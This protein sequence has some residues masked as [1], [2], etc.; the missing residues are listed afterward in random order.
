MR[1]SVVCCFAI[2]CLFSFLTVSFGFAGDKKPLLPEDLYQI[3]E[4]TDL[5]VS[6]DGQWIA[7]VMSVPNLAENDAERAIWLMPITG[8]TSRRLTGTGSNSDSPRWS[9]NGKQLAFIS[10]RE[11][12]RNLYLIDVSGGE[13]RKLTN[14]KTDLNSPIWSGKG[15]TIL[16]ASRVLP[17]G[18]TNIENWTKKELPKC[19]ARAIDRL[20]FRQWD[21]WLGDERNH[22]FLVRVADG[23][24]QDITPADADVPPVSLTTNHD[25]DMAPDGKE[26]CY[27]RND[28]PVLAISTNQDIFL[29]DTV[30]LKEKKLTENTALDHQPHYSPDGRYIAYTAMAKPGYESDTERLMLY[31]RKTGTHTV[32][33]EKLDRTVGQILWAPNNKALYFTCNDQ[34]HNSIYKV[35][36][37]GNLQL[38]SADGFNS[39]IVLTPQEERLIF[40]RGYN[41]MPY[42]IFSLGLVGKEKNKVVQLT[43]QNSEFLAQHELPKLEDFHFKGADDTLVHGYILRPP[44]FDPAK[45]YPVVLVIHGGPQG[46]FGD[47]LLT[48]WWTYQLISAPGYVGVFINPRGSSGYGAL[49]REQVSKDYGG[50]CF[51]DLMKGL[52]HVLAHYDFVDKEKCAA[53][54]GS[55]GGYSVN[56]IMGHSD[57]FKCIVSHA[58][59]YNLASF[60]GATEELWYAAWD[61]GETPWD[62]PKL[63][64]QW[65]PHMYAKNFKTPT[66]I[67]H[68]EMDF[69]VPFGESLQLFTTLQRRGIPSR[70]VVFP[71][72]GHI[73]TIPQNNVRWWKEIQRWLALYLK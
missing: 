28:A 32:L 2:V 67:T 61:L 72:E 50:R 58:G 42:E 19:E 49:F 10:N 69:R 54:G 4:L 71:D 53:V 21:R 44:G 35:D 1:K 23:S 64:V 34:G 62:E 47:E 8:G 52:D 24:S 14:S 48:T 70:L 15:E 60:Y 31:E 13:A 17:E 9:P 38:V 43:R 7:Y 51:E 65:S 36:L 20:L 12:T 27:T 25:F 22:L 16:C 29:L 55:F 6:P 57:R 30:T 56:W 18:K 11:K 68:G 37:K 26:V 40:L 39:S 3:K 45:K 5:Q 63:Y 46:M 73:F 59:L 33:T 66:L 41:H